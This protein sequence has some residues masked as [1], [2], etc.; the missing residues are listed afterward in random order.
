[1]FLGIIV[2][3]LE[4]KFNNHSIHNAHF[5]NDNCICYLDIHVDRDDINESTSQ[6]EMLF[7]NDNLLHKITIKNCPFLGGE[8][9][10][11]HLHIIFGYLF[12]LSLS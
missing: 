9:D 1:M 12:T 2:N 6:N 11:K 10:G 7:L 8:R 5:K 3:V 4:I